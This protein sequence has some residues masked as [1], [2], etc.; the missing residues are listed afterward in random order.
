MDKVEG[1]KEENEDEEELEVE[2]EKKKLEEATTENFGMKNK[3]TTADLT[4][5]TIQPTTTDTE[6]KKGLGSLFNVASFF[7]P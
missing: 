2:D 7:L 5:T 6:S 4:L 3:E 1:E